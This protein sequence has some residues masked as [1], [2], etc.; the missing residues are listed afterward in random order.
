[1][2][3][4]VPATVGATTP[5]A[6]SIVAP[7]PP[8]TVA[9]APR[10]LRPWA[11]A[12][13]AT[14]AASALLGV[15]FTIWWADQSAAYDP[16]ACP[17]IGGAQCDAAYDQLT[18]ANPLLTASFIAAGAFTVGAATLWA[19]D[20]RDATRAAGE[21]PSPSAAYSPSA[22]AAHGE[23]AA[24]SAAVATVEP[25]RAPA[26]PRPYRPPPCPAASRHPA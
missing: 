5:D 15:A 23:R 3:R 19:L 8:L 10:P 1:M 13:T 25:W 21:R 4:T 20:R 6:T 14:A 9:A 11:I 2:T 24:R 17:V 26:Q 18:T 7:P 22:C 12:A 16:V